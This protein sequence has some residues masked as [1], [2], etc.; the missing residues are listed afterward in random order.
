MKILSEK[1]WKKIR[2]QI[3][4]DIVNDI[5]K[6]IGDEIVMRLKGNVIVLSE[7]GTDEEV[8]LDEEV[9]KGVIKP[10]QPKRRITR[11]IERWLSK[12]KTR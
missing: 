9:S 8:G 5:T 3:V 1:E 7:K 12:I 10:K 2:E 11:F 6:E 4:E